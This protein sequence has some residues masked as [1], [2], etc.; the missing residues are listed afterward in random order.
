MLSTNFIV[1]YMIYFS[2]INVPSN[3]QRWKVA[4]IYKLY[5]LTTVKWQP[6]L[7]Q[8]WA[9]HT[10]YFCRRVTRCCNIWFYR[11]VTTVFFEIFSCVITVS[12][13]PFHLFKGVILFKLLKLFSTPIRAPSPLSHLQAVILH[14]SFRCSVNLQPSNLTHPHPPRSSSTHSASGRIDP[15]PPS[16][17]PPV[18]LAANLTPPHPAVIFHPSCWQSNSPLPAQRSSSIPAGSQTHPFCSAVILHPSWWSNSPLP[19]K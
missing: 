10:S 8:S 1:G 15:S 7:L 18:L 6:C 2:E 11:C 17:Y 19:P 13:H 16:D 14:L 9:G 12:R 5:W 4:G 3:L